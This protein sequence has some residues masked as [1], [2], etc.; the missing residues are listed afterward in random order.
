MSQGAGTVVKVG[1]NVKRVKPGD[2]VCLSWAFCR[3]CPTC[4]S[5]H[6]AHCIEWPALN[7]T[8]NRACGTAAFNNQQG[9]EVKSSFLGQSSFSRH[10]VADESSVIPVAVDTDLEL[11]SVLGCGECLAPQQR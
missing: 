10:V 3:T 7:L 11:L 6:P 5:G 8:G 1:G 2:K 9:D 4:H